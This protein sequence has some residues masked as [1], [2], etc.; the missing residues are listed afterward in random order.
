MS[1]IQQ[2][3]CF[4][5]HFCLRG[6]KRIYSEVNCCFNNQYLQNFRSLF[7]KIFFRKKIS[8]FDGLEYVNEDISMGLSFI[9]S[10]KL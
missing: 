4:V 6:L 10:L 9:Y 8:K 2:L 7:F 1:K 3:Q 5:L